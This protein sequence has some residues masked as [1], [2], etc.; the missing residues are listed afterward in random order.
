MALITTTALC[1]RKIDFSETSQILTLLTDK[2]GIVG[3][4]AKGAKREKS[5]IG[6]PLDLMCLYNVVLYDR[7]KRG[8]LSI[9][10]QAELLDFFPAARDRYERFMGIES[11]RELL[12]SVELGPH[13]APSVMLLT[14]KAMR[15]LAAKQPPQVLARFAWGLL[16]ALGVEP[17]V[18]ECVLTGAEPSGKVAVNFSLRE[19]GLI[20]P[21]HHEGRRDLVTVKPATLKALRALAIDEPADGIAVDAWA[22]AFTLLAW[23]V[24]MQGGRR[25]KTVPLLRT[26]GDDKR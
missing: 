16:R 25:L 1:L 10:A 6:G 11:I 21:P 24:A 7:S 3:A 18:T 13:D 5:S 12:L 19:M 2:L 17:V 26:T 14:V 23:L 4:I 9:L 22:A 15:E 8:T 20:A